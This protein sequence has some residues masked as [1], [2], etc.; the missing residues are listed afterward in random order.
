M[1]IEFLDNDGCIQEEKCSN[2][3]AE[4]Q[5]THI[6]CVEESYHT[7]KTKNL[8]I[9]QCEDTWQLSSYQKYNFKDKKCSLSAVKQYQQVNI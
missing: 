8:I 4:G 9:K 1:K 3:E 7:S 6:T 2:K 5:I